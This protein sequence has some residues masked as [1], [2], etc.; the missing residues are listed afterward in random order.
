MT[1]LISILIVAI[2]VESI[3]EAIKKVKRRGKV[4]FNTIISIVIGVLICVSANL[5]IF[6]LLEIEMAIPLVGSVMTGL[7]VSRSS[8]ATHDL[9]NK[10]TS[11]KVAKE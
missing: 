8:N 4:N 6:H 3:V 2:L 11:A 1:E 5:D 9:I 10:L 7:L